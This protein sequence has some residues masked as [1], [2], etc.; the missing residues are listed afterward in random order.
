MRWQRS[1]EGY[2]MIDHR[3]SPGLDHPLLGPG[4][5]VERATRNCSHCER[6]VVVNPDRTRVRGY[7][8]KCDAYVC[9]ACEAE[10]VRTGI[11]RPFKQVVDEFIDQAARGVSN[12]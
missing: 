5:F 9:D 4:S 7:C 1:K 10:R 2:L 12:G 11:C 3:A 6:L 8:P